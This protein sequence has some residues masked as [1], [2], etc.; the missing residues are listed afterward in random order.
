MKNE[1]P[2]GDVMA[3]VKQVVLDVLKPHQP[4][5]LDFASQ[6]AD[7]GKDYCVNLVVQEVDDKTHSIILKIS[8]DR[9][10][11]DV[12]AQHIA[13]M[14]ASVHSIDEVDVESEPGK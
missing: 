3:I 6:L 14:G 12:I 4:N 9:I 7:L 5:V 11:F 2:K 1:Q 8:G 13:A 10:E